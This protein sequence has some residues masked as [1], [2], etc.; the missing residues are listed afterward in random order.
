MPFHRQGN[1]T[2]RRGGARRAWRAP[3]GDE[4]LP[5]R[6]APPYLAAMIT[7]AVDETILE[8][9]HVAA[10]GVRQRA[11]APYSNY[12]VGA[13]VLA[14]DGKVYAGCNVENASYPV[15]LCAERG[16]IALAVARGARRVLAAALVT[17]DA[18][19]PCGLCLQTFAEFADS[20][21]PLL[22]S[23]PDGASTRT[24]LGALLP[25]G[26]RLRGG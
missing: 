17:G 9:L 6:P 23:V 14:D 13:A 2:P 15:G 24:T 25:Q 22:L 16:A 5:R 7:P 10:L 20:D 21:M 3:T 18:P 11:Y 26:F 4:S 12:A 1:L 19:L 8:R